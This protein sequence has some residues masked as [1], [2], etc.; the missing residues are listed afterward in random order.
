MFSEEIVAAATI[1]EAIAT[2][3]EAIATIVEAIVA[4]ATAVT[5]KIVK[6]SYNYG[7]GRRLPYNRGD[8]V[9][10]RYD[11]RFARIIGYGR[12]V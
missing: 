12:S 9:A 5:R 10:V 6:N 3:V 4:V 8:G 11:R 1:V 7:R 2:I